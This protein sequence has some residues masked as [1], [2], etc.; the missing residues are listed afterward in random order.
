MSLY[1]TI[2]ETEDNFVDDLDPQERSDILL[3]I[4]SATKGSYKLDEILNLDTGN[5]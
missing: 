4:I 2:R 1:T 5:L 3:D